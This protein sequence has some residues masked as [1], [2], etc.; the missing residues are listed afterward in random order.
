[1]P[2]RLVQIIVPPDCRRDVDRALKG[3][4][5]SG[6]WTLDQ[7]T[8][9]EL[10]EIVVEADQVEPLV[11]RFTD[12]FEDRKEFRI[13]LLPV[14]ATRPPVEEDPDAPAGPDHSDGSRARVSRDELRGN[15]MEQAELTWVYLAMVAASTVVAAIGLLRDDVAVIIGAMVIAPLLGPN[16]ALAMA[17][18]LAD[19]ELGKRAAV[20]LLAAGG[21]ALAISVAAGFLVTVDPSVAA[22]ADRTR[23][24]TSDL[25]LAFSAGVAGSLAFTSGFPQAVIGVMVAVALLPPLVIFGLLI[26]AGL[27]A[28]ATGA[29][30]LFLINVFSVNLAGVATFLVR[31]VRPAGW[32]DKEKARTSVRWAA[33]TWTVLLLLL[34]VALWVARNQGFGSF[35]E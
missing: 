1:M 32:S 12:C 18:T 4:E 17:A 6:R 15:A 26:G 8:G 9:A 30:I 25:L 23:P 7:P 27:P 19:L 5:P 34:L 35:A 11:D 2:L 3:A 14:E 29:A 21:T 10:M 13:T 22:I 33:L 20:S 24:G 31:G 16:V 28:L